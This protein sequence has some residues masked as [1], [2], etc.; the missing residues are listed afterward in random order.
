MTISVR[1]QDKT[2]GAFGFVLIF[3][4]H[5]LYQDK[6]WKRAIEYKKKEIASYL[7]MRE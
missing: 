1:W 6:K 4:L 7:A 2:G 3:L 5:F